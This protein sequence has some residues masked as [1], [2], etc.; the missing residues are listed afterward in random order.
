MSTVEPSEWRPLNWVD[1]EFVGTR[2]EWRVTGTPR[3]SYRQPYVVTWVDQVL[4]EDEARA[5]MA[6]AQTKGWYRGPELQVRTVTTSGWER[7]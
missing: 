4:A 7:V 1:P 2:K 3:P 5:Y 6:E